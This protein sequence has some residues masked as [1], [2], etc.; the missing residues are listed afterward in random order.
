MSGRA[1]CHDGPESKWR[2]VQADRRSVGQ[3]VASGGYY[4]QPARQNT[5]D[6]QTA[7]Q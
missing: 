1:F 2:E 6:H 3:A 4:A 5:N 7:D